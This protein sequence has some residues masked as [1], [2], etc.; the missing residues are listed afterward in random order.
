[1]YSILSYVKKTWPRLWKVEHVTVIPKVQDPQSPSECRNISCTNFL[2]K[3]FESFVL[4]WSRTE[5]KPKL[6]QYGGEPGASSTQLLVEVLSDVTVGLEDNRAGV[7]LSAIDFSKA[8]NRLDH[9]KVLEAFARKGSSTDMLQ[10]LS[11]F[12][13]DRQ[14]TVR[15]QGISSDLRPVNAGAPQ[16]S[17]LGCYLFNIGVDDLEEG[18]TPGTDTQ[19]E[20]HA[21]TLTQMDDYPAMSTPTRIGPQSLPAESPVQARESVRFAILPRVANVP[22]WVHKPKDPSFSEAEL[23]TFKY[24]DDEVNSS[25]VNMK[26]LRL[27]TDENGCPFKEVVDLK[28]QG[29]LNHIAERAQARGMVINVKK[30][31]LMLVSAATSFE[32]RTRVE[33][34]GETILGSKTLK[35]LGVT[36]DCDASF[37][38]HVANLA[39]KMRPKTWALA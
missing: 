29:L 21:E 12:L 6:N 16:G 30:T 23:H 25:K 34:G 19:R 4:E 32:P 36:L 8:F 15:L 9:L 35:I 2:S 5:V 7:V 37:N 33:L 31:D 18:F 13:S 24:V 39:T 38:M 26:K 27:L 14:M 11:S 22:H 1:M 3:L 28:T 20:A 10:L 17:V